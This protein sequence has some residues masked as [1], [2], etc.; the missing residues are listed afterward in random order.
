MSISVERNLDYVFITGLRTSVTEMSS[1]AMR[2]LCMPPTI[3]SAYCQGAHPFTANGFLS[4]LT[5]DFFHFICSHVIKAE[6]YH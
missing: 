5:R 1:E 6:I 2:S 3:P 4:L